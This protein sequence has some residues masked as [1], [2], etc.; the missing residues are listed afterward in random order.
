MWNRAA[1]QCKGL[2]RW[3]R[4]KNGHGDRPRA[5]DLQY[6]STALRIHCGQ[7]NKKNFL[8]P[9]LVQ[10]LKALVNLTHCL[11][12]G[13]PLPLCHSQCEGLYLKPLFA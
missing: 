12:N 2:R 1:F 7:L 6:G 4:G 8:L 11:V 9:F 3:A 5:T 10:D 13:I